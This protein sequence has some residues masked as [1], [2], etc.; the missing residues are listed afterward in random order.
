MKLNNHYKAIGIIIV[1]LLGMGTLTFSTYWISNNRATIN[2]PSFPSN[3]PANYN[4]NGYGNKYIGNLNISGSNVLVSNL[5]VVC[6]SANS[7]GISL[8]GVSNVS[9]HNIEV[10]NCTKYGIYMNKVKNINILHKQI[11][12]N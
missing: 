10:S 3:V 1:V 11:C 6:N 7:T 8:N 9:F 2:S 12:V 4:L 5:N